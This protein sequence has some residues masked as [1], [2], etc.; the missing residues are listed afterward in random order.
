LDAVRASDILANYPIRELM[1]KNPITTSPD[2]TI[3][4]AAKMML[5]NTISTLPVMQGEKL[6]G[7]ITE[8]DIF[9]AFV[10][11]HPEA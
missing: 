10:E 1:T 2:T 9:R 5:S 7:I 8:G 6:V 3:I 4:Q 11:S